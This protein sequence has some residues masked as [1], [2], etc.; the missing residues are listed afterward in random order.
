MVLRVGLVIRAHLVPR[1]A[2][3]VITTAVVEG[4]EAMAAVGVGVIR[5]VVMACPVLVRVVLQP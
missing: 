1:E 5:V 4:V 2:I 3:I